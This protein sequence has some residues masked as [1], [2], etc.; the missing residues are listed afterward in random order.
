MHFFLLLFIF[1]VGCEKRDPTPELKDGV[2]QIL[3]TEVDTYQKASEKNLKEIEDA[4]K[5]ISDPLTA[6]DQLPGAHKDLKKAQASLTINQQRMYYYQIRRNE[7]AKKVR[8]ES[9]RASPSSTVSADD[10]KYYEINQSLRN[11]PRDWAKRKP[12]SETPPPKPSH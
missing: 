5:K 8:A 9:L 10:R 1:L 2:Y 3:S 7:W 4:K 6:R 12:A 11:A